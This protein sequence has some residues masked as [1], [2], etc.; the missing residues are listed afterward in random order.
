MSQVDWDT[1]AFDLDVGLGSVALV[2]D[3]AADSV[4]CSA[5]VIFVVAVAVEG[6]VSVGLYGL[7]VVDAVEDLDR[8]VGG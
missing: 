2:V 8:S 6:A 7:A 5:V 3:S 1:Y 4:D